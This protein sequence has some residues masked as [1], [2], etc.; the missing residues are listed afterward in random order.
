M[1][2]VAE[3]LGT[4]SSPEDLGLLRGGLLLAE[5][6]RSFK[7]PRRSSCSTTESRWTAEQGVI[8]P[9]TSRASRDSVSD[10]WKVD[11]K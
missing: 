6:S 3:E 2:Q 7:L 11:L 1:R 9:P 8:A 4:A 5:D 10:R